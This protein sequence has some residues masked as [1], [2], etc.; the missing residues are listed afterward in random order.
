MLKQDLIHI[1]GLRYIV[2]DLDIRS[3]VARRRVLEQGWI[4]S[5]EELERRFDH[6][7]ATQRI[8][9]DPR[10]ESLKTKLSQL[11]DI[12]ST[13]NL[14]SE[15]GVVNDTDFFMIKSFIL[16]YEDIIGWCEQLELNIVNYVDLS[17]ALSVLDPD[18]HKVSAFRIYDSYSDE[19]KRLRDELK[20]NT[21]R[22]DDIFELISNCEDV[23]RCRLSS[24]LQ[25]YVSDIISAYNNVIYIDIISAQAEQAV[26]LG[27]VRPELGDKTCYRDLF[28][29]EVK[30][31]LQGRGVEYQHID[32]DMIATTP[33]LLTGANMGGKSV[34]LQS[35][36]LSQA[37]CQYGFYVPASSAVVELCD[38]VVYISGD[39]AD[40]KGGLS[41]FAA[42][43]LAVN[44]VVEQIADGHKPLVAI[45]ELART[46]N[47]VE[48]AA[49]V[50]AVVEYFSENRIR[51]LIATHYGD[52][53]CECCRLRIRGLECR[54]GDVVTKDNVQR[55]FNYQ[56]EPVTTGEVPHEALRIA[57]IIGVNRDITEKI[58]KLLTI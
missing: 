25:G 41:S 17:S 54:N 4:V 33:I 21:E 49:I 10:F 24:E 36:C 13:L 58:E 20:N 23:I 27:F 39:K 19:L 45:D 29:P 31:V 37:M 3:A 2:E 50:G 16:L 46:T 55:Y 35:V 6:I 57:T 22:R 18:G 47:P 11:K 44:R 30:K 34:L 26:R 43:M 40:A 14:V 53:R 12:H 51:S 52:V 5:S 48:G 1:E 8:V 28:Q 42:E 15:G 9:D 38:G 32:I 7:S 56:P